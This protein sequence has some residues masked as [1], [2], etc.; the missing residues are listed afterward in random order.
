MLKI[1]YSFIPGHIEFHFQVERIYVYRF[2]AIRVASGKASYIERV[3]RPLEVH[4]G[5]YVEPMSLY[6]IIDSTENPVRR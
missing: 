1:L 3:Q 5:T 6:S 4:E 2:N